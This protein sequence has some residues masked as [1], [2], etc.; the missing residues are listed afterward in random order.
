VHSGTLQPEH[1]RILSGEKTHEEDAGAEAVLTR[2][3][4]ERGVHAERGEAD[5]D[6]IERAHEHEGDPGKPEPPVH[7]GADPR[8]QIASQSILPKRFPAV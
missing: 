5:V 7:L 3:E 2:R 1:A 8:A 4:A 6:A